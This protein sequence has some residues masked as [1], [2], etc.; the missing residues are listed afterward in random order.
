[1][2][3]C[4]P[5]QSV[6]LSTPEFVSAIEEPCSKWAFRY[7]FTNHLELGNLAEF[8][9]FQQLGH[10]LQHHSWLCNSSEGPARTLLPGPHQPDLSTLFLLPLPQFSPSSCSPPIHQAFSGQDLSDGLRSSAAGQLVS[11]IC[12]VLQPLQPVYSHRVWNCG[13]KSPHEK[14]PITFPHQMTQPCHSSALLLTMPDAS[15][16]YL[17]WASTFLLTRKEVPWERSQW[18]EC[19]EGHTALWKAYGFGKKVPMEIPCYIILQV[20]PGLKWTSNHF[21]KNS[22]SWY[23]SLL[24]C[25]L[26]YQ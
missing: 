10:C 15:S 11:L 21:L 6:W 17:I 26:R 7:A 2:G 13:S 9:F 4:D 22:L 23:L 8:S 3:S 20:L 24:K 1:M 18:Q 12:Y 19:V 14:T 16:S 25:C 5:Q